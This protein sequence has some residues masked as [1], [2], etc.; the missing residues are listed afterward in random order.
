LI[1]DVIGA[2]EDTTE[3]TLSWAIAIL[4]HYPQVQRR[5]QEEL[6]VFI[7][8]HTRAPKFSQRDQI[9]YTVSVMKECMRYRPITCLGVPHQTSND[10]KLE[11]IILYIDLSFLKKKG[12]VQREREREKVLK[13]SNQYNSIFLY[14]AVELD[15]YIIPKGTIVLT[16][17]KSLHENPKVYENPEKF[18]PERFLNNTKSMYASANGK[19]SDRDHFNFGWGRRICPGIYLVKKIPLCEYIL[20]YLICLYLYE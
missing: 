9:P 5:I 16:S 8:E 20:L 12:K 1:A 7:N 11:L 3:T 19:V 6:D 14:Y 13:K 15:Q 2:G 10:G 4:C 18:V 17:M